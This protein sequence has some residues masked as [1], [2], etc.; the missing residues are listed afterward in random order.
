MYI[1]RLVTSAELA[2]L[3][4][5]LRPV[6]TRLALGLV[7]QAVSAAATLV[8]LLLALG[9]LGPLATTA[10]EDLLGWA[11]V[12]GASVLVTAL[13]HWASSLLLHLADTDLQLGLR[14]RVLAEVRR[15][16]L[17]WLDEH[18]TSHIK[19]LVGDDVDALHR[20]V[21]HGLADLVTALTV[22][23]AGG[24]ALLLHA[25]L[26]TPL[27]LL[28]GAVALL[29]AARQ[30]RELPTQMGRYLRA[31]AGL[32]QAAVEFV[33]GIAPL[34]VLGDE[35]AGLRRFRA[36]AAGYA[37]FVSGWA[38][39]MT[40]T[41]TAQQLLLSGTAA[42][43]VLVAAA[44]VV[45]ASVSAVVATALL[46]PAV[47]APAAALAFA[48]QALGVGVSAATRVDDLLGRQA[49]PSVAATEPTGSDP[50]PRDPP[51]LSARGITLRLG[52]RAVLTD[53]S[54]ECPAGRTTV[55]V[56]R[57]GAG[58]TTLLEVLGGLRSPDAGEVSVDGR[59]LQAVAG[60]LRRR[61]GLLE[62]RPRLLRASV[63]DNVRLGRP[64][65]RTD[66]CERAAGAAGVLAR[67]QELPDGWSTV[68]GSGTDLSGGERQRLCL[69][70]ALVGDPTLLLLDEPTSAVDR[71]TATVVDAAVGSGPTRTVVRVEHRLDVAL[72]AD[73][74]VV[75][76][77][78]RVV[79]AGDPATLAGQPGAF[80]DLLGPAG[81]VDRPPSVL[82]G[83]GS[84]R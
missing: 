83:R 25:P 17:S 35:D 60:T 2:A 36:A 39:R 7:L 49:G 50:L 56:G 64:A 48:V 51:G 73:H 78:G 37:D 77:E 81:P 58:K 82:S 29:L 5:L 34:K 20:L 61:T 70:R 72:T 21:G 65:A 14:R 15:R 4:R 6:R 22:S 47:L 38:R 42:L 44:T 52:G 11:L 43:A 1:I 19:R 12:A 40:P 33:R 75:L 67:V 24:L 28:P 13:A 55:L 23:V 10:P 62:Q 46:V 54:L 41:M 30:R 63:L 53:V 76:D 68:L 69:A 8:P 59:P 26:L 66:A 32:D 80:R 71:A 27:A 18:G 74:L 9:L 16:P 45:P 57:S 31:S 79:Q 3:S 84:H